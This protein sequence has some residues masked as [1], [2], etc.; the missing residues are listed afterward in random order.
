MIEGTPVQF[1]VKMRTN[2]Q[3]NL[4]QS[5]DDGAAEVNYG[6]G[7]TIYAGSGWSQ[8][9]N[10]PIVRSGSSINLPG[11]TAS[12]EVEL[13][14]STTPFILENFVRIT[15]EDIW[16]EPS[17]VTAI[18]NGVQSDIENCGTNKLARECWTYDVNKVYIYTKKFSKYILSTKNPIATSNSSGG[19]GSVLRMDSCP[20]GDYSYSYYDGICGSKPV[21]I[22]EPII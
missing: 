11:Y 20:N 22:A 13:G 15:I 8:T 16:T 7:Q 14:S 18:H 5:S 10:N 2:N 1:A 9:L 3:T 4:I 6:T 19:G 21:A 17:R 12:R